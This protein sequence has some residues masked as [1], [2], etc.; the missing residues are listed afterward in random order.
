MIASKAS[1]LAAI[2][3]A[4]P[5]GIAGAAPIDVTRF[6]DPLGPCD[7]TSGCSLRQAV[8]QANATPGADTITLHAGTYKL[9][10]KGDDSTAEAGDLDVTDDLTIDG[11]PA[12]GTIINA[13][14]GKDRAFEVFDAVAL[15]LG[16]VTVKGGSAADDGGAVFSVGTLTIHDSVITGNK[17]GDS[18]GGIA[19][20]A[21]TCTLTDDVITKNKAVDD[22]GGGLEFA[23]EGTDTVVRSTIS[24]NSAGDTG[25]GMDS[26]DGVTVS[27]A[28]CTISGNKS[29]TEGGG[30]DP[31]IGTV[32]V[33][34][35]TISGNKS[36]EGGGIQL[37]TGGVLVLDHVTVTKNSAK[38]GGGLWAEPGTTATLTATILA[39]NK[40]FDCF[41]PV[42]SNGFNLIGAV[43][44]CAIGGNTIGNVTGGPKP[45][46]PVKPFLAG[47]KDNGGPTKTHALQP[48]SP[49]IDAVTTGC[50]PPT[51]DQRGSPRSAP[52][53]IGA[54]EVQ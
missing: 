16:H 23:P 14:G 6:D 22:D 8:L 52:C 46:K 13:K 10:L 37:E 12:G 27:F 36:A 43:D 51:A 42:D 33:T 31:S 47:L 18:G 49:A 3:I 26:D 20:E 2:L 44:G 9:K 7:A 32:T 50:P 29:K 25:G 45:L 4:L 40:K 15:T 5:Y 39:G 28:G 19:C 24:K 21:G 48:G 38:E 17:A 30:L 35:T 1:L 41:G 11:D 34:N 54:F 53:D